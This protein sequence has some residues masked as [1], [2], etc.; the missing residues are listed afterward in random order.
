MN[1]Y[2][3]GFLALFVAA[4]LLA[5]GC[6]KSNSSSPTVTATINGTG[7]AAN[8]PETGALITTTG[9][10]V[11]GGI[12]FK[13]GDSTG[14]TLTFSSTANFGQPMVSTGPGSSIDV[15]YVDFGTKTAYDGGVTAG[16]STITVTSY[17]SAGGKVAGSFSG[18]LYNTSGGSDSLTVANGL[19]N[20]TFVKY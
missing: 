15:G 5:A 19:F 17:D 4:A 10:L 13:H 14:F 6:K 18:V 11:V 3:T 9:Q 12:Q 7:W 1:V 20:A 8:I 2:I 16:R